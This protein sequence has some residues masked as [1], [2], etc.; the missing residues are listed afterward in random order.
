M[1]QCSAEDAKKK[2]R[3][4][5]GAGSVLRGVQDSRAGGVGEL[6]GAGGRGG[7]IC[8]GETD[9]CLITAFLFR[10]TKLERQVHP[11]ISGVSVGFTAAL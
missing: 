2:M 1:A 4:I 6:E 8:Y 5:L 11:W 9:G 10:F 3:M 7:Q